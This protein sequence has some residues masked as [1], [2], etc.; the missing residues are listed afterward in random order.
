MKFFLLNYIY[1]QYSKMSVA[2]QLKLSFNIVFTGKRIYDDKYA[3]QSFVSYT[4][5]RENITESLTEF[6][7]RNEKTSAFA[8][9]TFGLNIVITNPVHYSIAETNNNMRP[10]FNITANG[11]TYHV[12][13]TKSHRRITGITKIEYFDFPF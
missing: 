3:D 11:D 12:F 7:Y 10:H 4:T 5:Q 8:F 1:Q 2:I 6:I 9:S 13:T